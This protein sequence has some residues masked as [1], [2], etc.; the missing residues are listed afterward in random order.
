[1][2]AEKRRIEDTFRW[3]D[4]RHPEYNTTMFRYKAVLKKIA[5][6]KLELQAA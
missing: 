2:N 3:M 6:I 4:Y 1:M 5:E